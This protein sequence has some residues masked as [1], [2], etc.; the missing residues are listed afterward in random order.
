MLKHMIWI[1]TDR[2]SGLIKTKFLGT[3]VSE[4]DTVKCTYTYKL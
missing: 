3:F 1:S 4:L 2:R